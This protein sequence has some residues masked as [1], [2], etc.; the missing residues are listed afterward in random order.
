[1]KFASLLVATVFVSQA[2]GAEWEYPA[3]GP[4]LTIKHIVGKAG[5]FSSSQ[6]LTKDTPEK[7]F[8]W[9]A[10][11]LGLSEDNGLVLKAK[12]GFNRIEKS[13]KTAGQHVRDADGEKWGAVILSSLTAD[14]A[15]V[16]IFVRPE[17]DPQHDITISIAQTGKGTLVTV[18]QSVPS[19]AGKNGA[20]TK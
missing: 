10:K 11:Q 8:L 16:Q 13:N 15:N 14:H 12:S 7:V 20:K 5:K 2:S 19:K 9:Y 3:G 4:T 1:M 18:I 6:T 17:N